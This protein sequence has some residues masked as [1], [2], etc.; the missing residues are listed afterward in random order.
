MAFQRMRRLSPR[1]PW[2]VK[3][4]ARFMPRT[5]VA[6]IPE[7]RESR[8]FAED[9][10]EITQLEIAE[11]HGSLT[12]AEQERLHVV[13]ARMK[14]FQTQML[15]QAFQGR[16]LPPIRSREA[17]LPEHLKAGIESLSGVSMNDV[18]VHYDSERPAELQA[19]ACAQGDEIHLAPGQEVHLSHE[20]W[21]VAQQKQGRVVPNLRVA[22]V[23][24]NEDAALE[25]EA[26][27]MGSRAARGPAAGPVLIPGKA[28]LPATRMP[29]QRAKKKGKK[30]KINE[31]SETRPEQQG[32]LGQEL[33]G[34]LRSE[35]PK[36]SYFKEEGKN[37]DKVHVIEKKEKD[38]A[39]W[40]WALMALSNAGGPKPEDLWNYIL[41]VANNP[42]W[43]KKVST[44]VQEQ[45]GTLA[46]RLKKANLQIQLSSWSSWSSRSSR[47]RSYSTRQKK[48]AAD[49]MEKACRLI[50]QAHGFEIAD[51]GEPAGWVVCQYK[52]AEGAAVPEHWWI[53]LS[54]GVVI[55]TIPKE[56]LEVGSSKTKFH[57]EGGRLSDD[58]DD[59]REIRV[60]VKA[61]KGEHVRILKEGMEAETEKSKKRKLE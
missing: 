11:K 13:Q 45:L 2:S 51:K 21:H 56:N 40:N 7:S 23:A 25:R 9:R 22:G 8:A 60:P 41:G 16:P 34:W 50:V 38:L 36:E 14:D 49:V 33:M 37:R 30:R 20:A 26:D 31:I 42:E 32:G 53:E 48:E 18:K 47:P 4:A 39:C 57:T 5:F 54:G 12:P 3:S 58:A 10:F 15:A 6:R 24:I 43:V 28:P 27:V 46:T 19:L 55:Q 61:L 17:A 35:G 52:P 29:V 44:E 59:Y 1:N